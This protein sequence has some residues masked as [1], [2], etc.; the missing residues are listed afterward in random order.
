MYVWLGFQSRDKL[1]IVFPTSHLKEIADNFV[2][3]KVSYRKNSV[4]N[5][6]IEDWKKKTENNFFK[7]SNKK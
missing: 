1:E 4:A 3:G 6:W 5:F 7:Y 2:N